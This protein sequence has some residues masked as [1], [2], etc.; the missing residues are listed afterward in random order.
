VC[1][2]DL[3]NC[4]YNKQPW[5]WTLTKIYLPTCCMGGGNKK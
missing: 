3:I 2:V 4:T 5:Q 1:G